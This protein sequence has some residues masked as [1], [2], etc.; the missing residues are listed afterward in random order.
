MLNS[1]FKSS[2][3]VSQGSLL[4]GSWAVVVINGFRKN[5][6]GFLFEVGHA[7]VLLRHCCLLE[8]HKT[9]LAHC[10]F[11]SKVQ[12]KLKQTVVVIINL[13]GFY[14]P[15]PLLWD[16]LHKIKML[17]G[18]TFFGYCED[19]GYYWTT[20]PFNPCTFGRGYKMVLSVCDRWILIQVYNDNCWLM[21]HWTC[22]A[23]MW[24]R[25]IQIKADILW[26]C[27]SCLIFSF[28]H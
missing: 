11:K 28:Y 2:N 26:A 12:S 25:S 24:R 7:H 27:D 8:H 23:Q 21:Q 1:P 9:E 18:Q 16:G 10:Y 6:P 4:V 19:C 13:P 20:W 3:I 5:F 14:W 17:Q 15:Q 22:D